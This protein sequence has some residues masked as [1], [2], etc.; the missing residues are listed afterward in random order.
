MQGDRLEIDFKM[1]VRRIEV[2][3]S[4]D[5]INQINSAFQK[6][7]DYWKKAALEN[8]DENEGNHLKDLAPLSPFLIC[9]AEKN[10]TKKVDINEII[11]YLK[12]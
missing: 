4:Q 11:L 7:L 12:S 8:L 10:N 2:C 1:D 9:K 5:K 3:L 6:E